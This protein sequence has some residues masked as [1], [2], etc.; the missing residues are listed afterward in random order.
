VLAHLLDDSWQRDGASAG[1]AVKQ[2]A[3]AQP[4]VAVPVRHRD[5]PHGLSGRCYLIGQAGGLRHGDRG[6]DQDC[7]TGTGDESGRYRRPDPVPLSRRWLAGQCWC[8][9]GLEDMPRQGRGWACHFQILLLGSFS[10]AS[11]G[12][13]GQML[14]LLR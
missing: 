6:I 8:R 4:V 7:V 5:R 11:L 9:F 3:H 10:I 2:D 13:G 1:K 12:S 14:P